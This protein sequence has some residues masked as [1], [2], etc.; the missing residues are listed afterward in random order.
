MPSILFLNR[1]Y[2]PDLGATGLVVEQAALECVAAGWKVSVLATAD[3]GKAEGG[4]VRAGVN[5]IRV[6]IP[7]SKK[8]L[9]FRAFGYVLMI[10]SLL[11]KSLWL[12]P[13]DVVVTKT[14]PPMLLVIGPLLRFLKGGRLVHWAQDLYPEVAEEAGVFRKRGV[15]ASV[16]RFLST[17]SIKSHDLTLA[18]GECMADRIE[19]RGIHRSKIRVVPNIGIERGIKPMPRLPNGFRK[20]NG[21]GEA[22]LVMYSG[23]IGRAHEFSTVLDAARILE[24]RGEVEILFVFVGRGPME[25]DLREKAGRLNLQNVRFIDSQPSES[26]SESLGAADLHLVTMNKGMEGLVVPSKFYGVMAASRPCLFVGP[27]GS[28]VAR[29]IREQGVGAVIE[30]GDP[31]AL[32]YAILHFRSRPDLI[33]ELGNRGTIYLQKNYAPHAFVDCVRELLS[34]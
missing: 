25:K 15:R 7:F 19:S 28:D 32:V 31:A 12:P 33:A 6:G 13:F 10:P 1:V 9:F 26:L 14:D 5:V 21:L 22:F 16:L 4:N 8:N 18:V 20:R 27:K 24:E 2:P 34:S 30:P 3:L 29:V 11:L 23:N 17:L